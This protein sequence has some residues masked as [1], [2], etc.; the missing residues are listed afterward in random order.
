MPPSVVVLLADGVRPDTLAAAMDAG[1]LPALAR[2]RHEGG[3]HEVSTVFP[4]VTGPAYSPFLMGRFP[5]PIGLPGIRWFDR[6]RMACSFPDYSRSYVGY[7]IRAV[8]QDLAADAPTI[9]EL[10]PGSLGA[11]S[12]ITRGLPPAQRVASLTARSALR[13][14]YT[15]FTGNVAGWL[16]VDREVA[17]EVV[18]RVATEHPAYTW[19]S[20]TG[21]DKASHARG[22]GDPTVRDAL[23]IV[24]DTAARIRADAERDGRWQDMHLWIVSDHGHSPVTSHED[25]AGLFTVM[26]HRVRAHPWVMLPFAQTAVMVSGNAMA[27][28]YLELH[29]RTRPWWPALAPRHEGLISMLLSRPSVDLVMLPVDAE[30]CEVRSRRGDVGV[31]SLIAGHYS[32]FPAIGDPLGVGR[33]LQGVDADEAYEATRHTDYPDSVVQIARLAASPRSGDIILSAARGWDFRSRY[34]PIPHVSSH[35]ALHREHM[36]VPLLVNRPVA[37]APRRTTD[38]MPSTLAALGLDMPPSLDG[39]SFL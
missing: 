24:D 21:V 23:R 29:R 35:G 32:Y 34:E 10:V 16:E 25:L 27:H 11:L 7:Q 12:V 37:R 1:A 39:V 33:G 4:S 22:Q 19:A 5:G 20:F 15:H 6:D 3:F 2:L 8:D 18:R 36:L 26:G 14:A 30:R 28:L 38:V 17:D 31:V 13:A 9:F